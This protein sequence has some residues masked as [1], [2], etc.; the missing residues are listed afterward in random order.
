MP[1]NKAKFLDSKTGYDLHAPFYDRK[2]KF[3]NSFEP[4]NLLQYLGNL[5]N[6]TILDV[7]AG[8]GRLTTKLANLNGLVT[9][10][11]VSEEILKV[12]KRKNKNIETV[13]GDAENLPFQDES[14][15]I[16][17]ATFLIVHLKD[18]LTF[19]TEAHRVL[20]HAGILLVTNISQKRPPELPTNQGPIV[21][22][23]YYH[24]PQKIKDQLTSLAFE[25]ETEEF[26]YEKNVWINQ[27]LVCRK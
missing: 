4:D 3:L 1:K 13:L 8:T 10:L 12:L 2:M 20:N 17:I 22:E 26:I 21:I 6:K 5:Q 19:F 9:A 18:P 11:D 15:D 16:I 27:I 25:I 23:S 24:T 7:G 14:F